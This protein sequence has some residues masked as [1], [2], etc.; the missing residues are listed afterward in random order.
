MSQPN[1]IH[2]PVL[3]VSYV[4]MVQCLRCRTRVSVEVTAEEL[5]RL[6]SSERLHRTCDQC[7]QETEWQYL[8][9]GVS[10]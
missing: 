4:A 1:Y 9:L 7:G 3:K 10:R 8:P 5:K 2:S 6:R